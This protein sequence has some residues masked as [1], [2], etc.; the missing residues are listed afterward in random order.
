[1]KAI[2]LEVRDGWAAALRE[3][4]VVVKTRQRAAVGETVELSTKTVDFPAR[5]ARFLRTAVAAVLALSITGGAYTYTNVAAASYVTLDTEETSVEL[6]LN[7]MGRVVGVRALDEDSSELAESLR[8]EL[9]RLRVEDAVDL[10]MERM[11]GAS[12]VVAG[13][14]G[15]TEERTADLQEAVERGA[16][17]RERPDMEFVAFGVSRE[18]R[19]AAGERDMSAGRWAFERGG[20]LWRGQPPKWDEAEEPDDPDDSDDWEE[21]GDLDDLDDLDNARGGRPAF[22]PEDGAAPPENGTAPRPPQRGATP[23]AP[24]GDTPAE[25]RRPERDFDDDRTEPEREDDRPEQD[26]EPERDDEDRSDVDDDDRFER[27]E[28]DD[29]PVPPENA[30]IPPDDAQTQDGGQPAQ[31]GAQPPNDGGQPPRGGMGG[32]PGNGPGGGTPQR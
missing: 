15:E 2:I 13:V 14:T 24:Q 21:R 5:R 32:D 18:E 20:G 26:T 23:P 6:S 9:C 11:G 1:M 17:R 7:R 4:G 10:A 27:E 25:T 31:G 28:G 3:D 30:Q 8:P 16:T 29:R 22:A 12:T 19:R